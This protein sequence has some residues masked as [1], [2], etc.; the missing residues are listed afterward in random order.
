VIWY[1][2]YKFENRTLKRQG[3]SP[4]STYILK[5]CCRILSDFIDYFD[6]CDCIADNR[7]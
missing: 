2:L 5:V 7:D 1:E 6:D 3:A 4:K